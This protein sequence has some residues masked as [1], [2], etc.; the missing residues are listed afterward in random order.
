MA[1]KSLLNRNAKRQI[2]C[3]RHAQKRLELKNKIKESGL[4]MADRIKYIQKL[5]GMPVDS[6]KVR[7]RNRC[8]VTGRGRGYYRDYG[9]SRIM[10]R[11]YPHYIP[12]IK[13]ASW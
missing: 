9:I 7:V 1:K 6:S 13:K 10:L 8:A 5:D 4:S 12:G 2:L 3:E 11:L